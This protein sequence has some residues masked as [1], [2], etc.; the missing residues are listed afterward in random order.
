MTQ[1]NIAQAKAH[2]SELIQK[3]MLGEEVIIAKDH[4]PLVKI[5]PLPQSQKQRNP[6]SGAG[7]LKY[8]AEDFDAP[9]EDFEEYM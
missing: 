9:L 4:R 7:Q 2:F 1:L 6:G 5:V 3:A 8:M